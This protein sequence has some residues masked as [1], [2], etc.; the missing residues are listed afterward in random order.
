MIFTL[1]DDQI[2]V[3]IELTY[4]VVNVFVFMLIGII[5]NQ[6][7]FLGVNLITVLNISTHES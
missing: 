1:K 7:L 4:L 5:I 6:D 3:K 2:K